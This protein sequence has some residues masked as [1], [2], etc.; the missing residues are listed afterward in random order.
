MTPA[1]R[2]Q[3]GLNPLPPDQ[4]ARIQAQHAALLAG[5]GARWPTGLV[6][7]TTPRPAITAAEP[8]LSVAETDIL[9]IGGGSAGLAAGA[10]PRSAPRHG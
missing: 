2:Q 9:V 6:Q 1:T 4:A 10:D 7:P 5:Q 3:L 8:P